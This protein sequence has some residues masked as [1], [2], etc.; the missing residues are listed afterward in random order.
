MEIFVPFVSGAV[1]VLVALLLVLIGWFQGRDVRA[2]QS[3]NVVPGEVLES[4]VETYETANSEG[5][6]MTAHR[7]R[8]HYKY[9]VNDRE[10]VGDKL[11]F[12]G[13]SVHSSL[14]GRAESKTRA[15]PEGKAVQVYVNPQNPSE[16]VLELDAPGA[17]MLNIIGIVLGVL[18]VL[19]CIGGFV[20]GPTLATPE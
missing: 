9:R 19:L 5:D 3:W 4:K 13:E 11:N 16:A 1:F 14:R 12:G 7:A 2:A 10:Y 18:G 6:T 15:Y 8:I 17:R 20:F